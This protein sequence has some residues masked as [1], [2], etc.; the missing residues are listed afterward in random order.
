MAALI[1]RNG[2]FQTLQTSN[3][4]IQKAVRYIV[5]CIG[6]SALYLNK[7][8]FLWFN[9]KF[10]FFATNTYHH[11]L[12]TKKVN[13]PTNTVSALNG[14]PF[15]CKLHTNSRWLIAGQ[16]PSQN[17]PRKSCKEWIF[18]IFS[19]FCIT[20][21]T[22]TTYDEQLYNC[23]KCQETDFTVTTYLFNS[24]TRNEVGWLWSNCRYSLEC[25]VF[26]DKTEVAKLSPLFFSKYWYVWL[27]N[28]ATGHVT[29]CQ[30]F[31]SGIQERGN[32]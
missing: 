27:F 1:S 14:W 9:V 30:T 29:G 19:R 23:W 6:L 3:S 4:A 22:I 15:R 2:W 32:I 25:M 20:T 31:T 10:V 24:L 21:R 28:M 8:T 26:E 7:F 17:F 11:K 12:I 18:F 5:V 13:R 16:K